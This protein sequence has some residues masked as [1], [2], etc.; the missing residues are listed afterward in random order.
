MNRFFVE[1]TAVQ[2]GQIVITDS[3]DVHHAKKVLRLRPG[4]QVEVSDS[5]EFEYLCEIES[6]GEGELFLRIL[7]KQAFAKEPEL[8]VT[9]YQ[10]APKQGKM[11]TIVQKCTELGVRTIVPV[12]LARSVVQEKEGKGEKKQ[13]R[14]QK[15]ADEAAKQCKRGVPARVGSSLKLKGLL[16]ELPQYDLV[17]IPYEDERK[18]TLKE[19]L[20][21][22]EI[23]AKKPK[24]VAVIIGPEGGFSAE[25]VEAVTAAGGCAVSLGKTILRTE[26]AGMA[27]LAMIMYELEME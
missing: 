22:E 19:V 27:A 26:T 23:Q 8:S 18:T 6:F 5:S 20:R 9:L 17:L 15:V 24:S 1:K 14:W 21:S 12:Y 13:E 7:D 11:E 16:A 2:G 3:Q 25:E 10:G 4:E